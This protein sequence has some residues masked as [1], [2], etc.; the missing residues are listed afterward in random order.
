[1]ASNQLMACD[2]CPYR[3][4]SRRIKR[5]RHSTGREKESSVSR[6]LLTERGSERARLAFVRSKYFGRMSR[7]EQASLQSQFNRDRWLSTRLIESS[8]L[9]RKCEYESHKLPEVTF[10]SILSQANL[11]RRKAMGHRKPP[12]SRNR[13][14]E[15]EQLAISSRTND[16]TIPSQEGSEQLLLESGKA[17]QSLSQQKFLLSNTK[18]RKKSNRKK[19]RKRQYQNNRD[20]RDNLHAHRFLR[21]SLLNRWESDDNFF[22]RKTRV[23]PVYTLSSSTINSQH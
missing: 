10:S 5:W 1:M 18:V 9:R 3:Q 4:Q 7:S 16:T 8:L 23:T 20:K 2:S 15:G 13:P 17:L 22:T 14:R 19:R 6:F 21:N 12:D 11:G